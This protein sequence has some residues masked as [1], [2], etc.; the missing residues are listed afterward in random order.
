MNFKRNNKIL[1]ELKRICRVFQGKMILAVTWVCTFI[2]GATGIAATQVYAQDGATIEEIIVT[3]RKREE[4]L[5][6]VPIS[7]AAF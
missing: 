7:I 2:I 5:Q 1:C 3:A 6:D 4:R